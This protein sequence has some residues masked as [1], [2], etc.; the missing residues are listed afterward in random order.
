MKLKSL[1]LENFKMSSSF[2]HDFGDENFIEG[3][4]GAG[5]SMIRDA[6]IFCL[7]NRTADGSAQDSSNFIKNGE[8][9]AVAELT[10][11][12]GDQEYTIKRERTLIST[13]ITLIDGSQS[14]EDSQITQRDLESLIPEYELF[15]AVFNIGYFMTLSDKEKRDF[16]LS[17]TPKV[18][19]EKIFLKMIEGTEI[20]NS[21]EFDFE[22]IRKTHKNILAEIREKTDEITRLTALIDNSLPLEI[23][24]FDSELFAKKLEEYKEFE[25]C[26]K[27]FDT[28]RS[29]WIEYRNLSA[30][31]VKI[32]SD[33]D[34]LNVAIDRIKIKE[35]RKPT[36][37]KLNNLK[38]NLA[39]LRTY[40]LPK[41]KCPT[42]YQNIDPEHKNK[43]EQYND[44]ITQKIKLLSA[45]IES[46]K[47]NYKNET[48]IW[49]N[50][51]NKKQR[52]KILTAR[53][54]PLIN[55]IPPKVNLE[56]FDEK[57][58]QKLKSEFNEMDK[59]REL[60]KYQFSQETRRLEE[61]KTMK[62]SRKNA[63]DRINNLN[64][65]KDIFS[66]SGIPAEE[67]RIKMQPIMEL[68]NKFIPK[69]EIK[70]LE[71]LKSGLDSKEVFEIL[72]DGKN[73]NR[74]SLGEKTRVNIALSHII[75]DL[76]KNIVSM[77]FLD[78]SE[79]LDTVPTMNKQFFI[80]KVT[81][82][83]LIIK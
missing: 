14:E 65:L 29:E 5:K 67:M 21:P 20:S 66:P 2:Y 27:K 70:T 52:I 30:H 68:F 39:S 8:N 58:F 42:C 10:F 59:K 38:A 75:D 12:I 43:V 41:E 46:E 72:V 9:K 26:K 77:F 57:P 56:M 79:I 28:I 80:A 50:N 32:K 22:D 63:S 18:D 45:D 15:Q 82:S 54:K 19:K 81:N 47:I 36:Q 62:E 16:I 44:K 6:I 60:Y 53:T 61:L 71:L 40:D 64:K 4:N 49:K 37:I 1:K 13:K 25:V 31:N 55:C 76:S 11:L 69:S 23:I 73:Y 78:N 48:E 7:Y 33:N 35:I 51:E 74:M 24:D 3:K 17:L 83:N 34:L